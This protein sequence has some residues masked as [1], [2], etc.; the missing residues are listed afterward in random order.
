[1]RC[2]L[3]MLALLTISALVAFSTPAAAISE[4]QAQLKIKTNYLDVGES[5]A[6]QRIQHRNDAYWILDVYSGEAFRFSVAIND[7]TGAIVSNEE[8]QRLL[9]KDWYL[10]QW[11]LKTTDTSGQARPNSFQSL[12]SKISSVKDE[13]DVAGINLGQAGG[14]EPAISFEA[15]S[16]KASA[17][18]ER[19]TSLMELT[20]D[21]L[22]L[23]NGLRATPATDE[24]GL[25]ME[26]YG[27]VFN[28]TLKLA[29]DVDGYITAAAAK[30]TEV[31]NSN[32]TQKQALAQL[33]TVNVAPFTTDAR[34]WNN[35]FGSLD[36]TYERKA[37]QSI[38]SWTDRKKRKDAEAKVKSIQTDVQYLL[39][40]E[41]N[42]K[43]CGI[44]EIDQIKSDWSAIGQAQTSGDYGA[45][46][47]KAAAI[48][49]VLESTKNK[50]ETCRSQIVTV[51][52]T[53]PSGDATGIIIPIVFVVI[54]VG[55][56]YYIWKRR[57]KLAG[58]L[59][60]Q[61]AEEETAQR[62]SFEK[63]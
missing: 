60:E 22:E 26:K 39:T 47:Q 23:E 12:N 36:Q 7:D 9:F 63:Q 15:L 1:M 50:Y 6:S 48:E 18:G 53:P 40:N 55:A 43:A 56:A 51:T 11:V 16:E 30:R 31:L 29:E 21:G 44:T 58:A 13:F 10:M 19:C 24:L 2:G 34:Y 33:L 59:A 17:I 45:M 5:I 4:E 41:F 49:A 54:I 57:Q 25:V 52:P 32:S 3:L 61:P 27:Q 38:A 35:Y 62:W 28:G 20:S 14:L 42:V 8:L 46:Y 37:N